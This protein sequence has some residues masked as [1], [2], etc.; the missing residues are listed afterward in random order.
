MEPAFLNPTAISEVPLPRAPLERV[1]S[2]IR[3]PR[4]LAIRNP[5]RVAEFQEFLHKDY[6]YLT[7]DQVHNIEMTGDQT[8]NVQH[9]IIW[10]LADQEENA[11]WRVSLGVNFVALETS[12]YSNRDDFLN[13]LKAVVSGVENTFQPVSTSRIGLR[14]IDR[15]VDE[16]VERIGEF[17]Q[18]KVLGIYPDSKEFVFIPGNSLI[19]SITEAQFLAKN[20]A[21][22][23]GRWGNLPPNTTYDPNTID[24]I[25]R[26]SWV[27]DFDMFKSESNAFSSEEI[28]NTANEF[29]ESL[30][31]LFRQFV[32]E[33]FLKFYGGTL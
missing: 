24:P 11:S 32:T 7:E 6:P 17:F 20:N 1:I 30:Y 12:S 19:H 31:W 10:R 23:Q 8:P 27:L 14:Y 29:A 25:S 26:P 18:P 3:F 9:S 4:I 21:R 5:D 2:Q 15:L 16:A 33:E 22:V 28:L 13:R